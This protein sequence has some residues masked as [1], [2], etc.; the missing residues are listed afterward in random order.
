MSANTNENWLLVEWSDGGRDV[1]YIKSVLEPN[2]QEL[3]VGVLITA[4]RKGEPQKGKLIDRANERESLD[5]RLKEMDE[6]GPSN[7]KEE[8]PQD[9]SSS[10]SSWVP[11]ERDISTDSEREARKARLDKY[12]RQ[13]TNKRTSKKTLTPSNK[14]SEVVTKPTNNNDPVKTGY[15]EITIA[16]FLQSLRAQKT[17]PYLQITTAPKRISMDSDTTLNFHEWFRE[18]FRSFERV[19]CETAPEHRYRQEFIPPPIIPPT[20]EFEQTNEEDI[21]S[22]HNMNDESDRSDDIVLITNKHDSALNVLDKTNETNNATEV[23]KKEKKE[24]KTEWAPIGSGKTLIH[25]DQFKKINWSSYTKATRTLLLAVFPRRVLATHSLTGKRSPAFLNKP[26]KLC[27][28]QKIIAD[29]IAEIIERFNVKENLVRSII[30]TKC[31]DE[32]KMWRARKIKK[33]SKKNQENRPPKKNS[34]FRVK[35]L[36]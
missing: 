13:Y 9:F 30:T 27:L 36:N 6:A 33:E 34:K 20:V 5:A 31:A 11:S 16:N 2:V 14:V 24:D 12:L 18:L 19:K 25:M 15:D 10:S 23:T 22:E 17:E 21:E 7:K 35:V 8:E 28:D 26:P 32:C 1:I 4:N 29:V 3:K